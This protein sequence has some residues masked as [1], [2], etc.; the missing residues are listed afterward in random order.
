MI[1]FMVF[2]RAYFPTT[3]AQ[4]LVKKWLELHI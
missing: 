1:Y 4:N 2:L 3:F